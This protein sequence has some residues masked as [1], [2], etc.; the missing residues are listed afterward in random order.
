[1]VCDTDATAFASWGYA[2]DDGDEMMIAMVNGA[3]FAINTGQ[4]ANIGSGATD[5]MTAVFTSADATNITITWT[6][7]NAGRDVT[8]VAM[9]K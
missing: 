5:Q 8:C 1:M 3:T 4:I 2:D 7:V 9:V 6:K